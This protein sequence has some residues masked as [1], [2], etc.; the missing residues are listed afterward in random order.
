MIPKLLF[1]S[2]HNSHSD[3]R[4]LS[5]PMELHRYKNFS[6]KN[7]DLLDYGHLLLC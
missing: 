5:F 6:F 7:F 4:V 1:P 3:E 2:H